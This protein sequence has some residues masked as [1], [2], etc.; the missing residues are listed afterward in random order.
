MKFD[1]DLCLNLQYDFGKMNSTIGSFVPLAM[2]LKGCHLSQS[3]CLNSPKIMKRSEVERIC[4]FLLKVWCPFQFRFSGLQGHKAAILGPSE[5]YKGTILE[6]IP[7]E[8][9]AVLP[10]ICTIVEASAKLLKD[11]QPPSGQGEKNAARFHIYNR[12]KSSFDKS[13]PTTSTIKK[14]GAEKQ[15]IISKLFTQYRLFYIRL[16]SLSACCPTNLTR[17]NW[18]R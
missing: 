17:P 10:P 12:G 9:S 13:L 18:A 14:R 1:Q 8:F 11:A 6:V 3:R 2:F 16:S 15:F 4:F 7:A 5:G